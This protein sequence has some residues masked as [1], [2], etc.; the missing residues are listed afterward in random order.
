MVP[1]WSL[2]V[3]IYSEANNMSLFFDICIEHIWP[4]SFS[5]NNMGPISKTV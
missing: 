1:A 3:F 2:R 4:P 5:V